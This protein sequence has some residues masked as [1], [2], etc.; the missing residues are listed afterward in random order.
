MS[1]RFHARVCHRSR[2]A[3]W[4][5]KPL[6]QAVALL[7]VAGSWSSTTQA[8][9]RAFSS[10]WF[11]DKNAVQSTAQRTGRMPD[12]SLAGI[13][14]SARQ[15]AESRLKLQRS[16]DNLNRTAAAV[17]AQQAAQAAAR[18]AAAA[19]GSSV[20]DGLT[21]GGLWV[22][23]GALAKWE[24]AKAPQPGTEGGRQLVTIEQTQS[25]AILNWD[26]FNVGRNTTV[27]FKQGA[28]D[29]VLNRVVGASAKP[30]QIQGAIKGDGT[31]L[32]V[33]QNG[34]IFTGTSQVN[35]RNLVVAAATMTDAQLRERGIYADAD[36]T[37]PTFKDALGTIEVQ[38][39]ARLSTAAPG[40]ATR[41]G[42][43]VLLAGKEVHNAGEIS[44]PQG[45]A[46]LAAGDSFIIRRGQGS[47]SNQASTTRGNEVQAAGQGLARNSG[48]I[49]SPQGDITLTGLRVEQAGVVLSTTSVDARGTIHLDA[50]GSGA[51][52]TL[53]E[54]AVSAILVDTSL[55]TALDGQRASLL[56]PAVASN[57]ALMPGDT[58]RR[59]LSL[60]QIG[61]Q[62][63]VDFQGGSLTLAT[64]GQVAVKA[65]GRALVQNG[66]RIDVGGA[67]GVIVSMESNN[68]KINLQGNEQRDAPVNRDSKLLN[69][70]DVWLDR[71]DLVRLAAGSGGNDADR[72]Y[73]AGGL[74]EVGGY[75]GTLGVPVSHWLAQGGVV[76]FDG[77]EVVTQAGS[78]I[79]LSGGTLDVQSGEI[80]QS[81]LR[82]E[83]GRLYLADRAPGDLLY[84]GLYRGY[85]AVS[86]R[87]GEN[88]TRRF[89]NPLIAPPTRYESGYTVGRDAG[90]LVVSTR[91]AVLDGDL[92]ND[93]YQGD[94]Q[95]RPPV[96]GMDGY[97]ASHRVAARAA[98]LVVGT[99]K[100]FYD[101]D[102][103]FLRYQLGAAGTAADVVVGKGLAGAAADIDLT[104]ALPAAL[105]GKLALDADRLNGFGLGAIRLAAS[106]RV[107][108]DA[109]L[110]SADGGEIT[111]YAPSVSVNADLVSRGGLI[112]AGNV[113][114]QPGA[115][116]LE[117]VALAP[118]AGK[119]AALRVASGVL[120]D[121]RGGWSNLKQDPTAQRGLPWL[122]G[123]RIALRAT[124]D[125]AVDAG[126]LLDVSSG[127]SLM[128]NGEVRGG[129]GGSVTLEANVLALSSPTAG[130]LAL[131]GQ[132]RGYGMAGAGKLAVASGGRIVLGG[133]ALDDGALRLDP[134]L[135]QSGFANYDV[136]GHGGLQ[137]A[138]AADIDVLVPVLRLQRAAGSLP[139]S[140][141]DPTD[142]LS[143][144]TPPRYA[145]NPVRG[146]LTQRAGAGLALRSDR[147][148]AGG[149]IE[150]G[151]GAR[152]AVD[153]GQTI[154]I[155]GADQIT[156]LGRLQAPGG[157]ISIMDARSGITPYAP[158]ASARSVWIGERAVLDV[159]G[160][161]RVAVAS[162]GR[163]YGVARAG[164]AIRIGGQLDWEADAY[165]TTRPMD[166]HLVLRPGSL[167]DA[168]GAQ[169]LV[170]MPGRGAT[171]L[172][173]NGGTLVLASASSLYL[174]GDLRAAAGGPGALGG[175]LALELMAGFYPKNTVQAPVLAE[176]LLTLTQT[177]GPS[178][179]P[180]DLRPGQTNSALQYGPGRLGVDQVQA[181]GFGSLAL[182]ATT[183]AQGDLTLAMAQSLRL[184]GSLSLADGA[185]VGSTLR[186]SAP[187][188][189]LNTAMHEAPA[190]GDSVVSPQATRQFWNKLGYRLQLQ[191]GMLDVRGIRDFLVFDD[192]DLDVAGDMRLLYPSAG[193]SSAWP[194]H[195][196]APNRLTITAAQIYPGIGGSGRISAGNYRGMYWDLGNPDAVLTIR[197]AAGEVPAVPY[198][199][200]GNL[201][202]SAPTVIQGGV[203][204]APFGAVQIEGREGDPAVVRFLPGS[205]T[206]VSGQGLVMPFGGTPD[207]LKYQ[208]GGKD[209]TPAGVS[210]MDSSGGYAQFLRINA[211]QIE[212]A[213]GSVL[214]LAGGGQLTGS[215]FV[216]G[217]GGSVDVLKYAMA[218]ANPGFGFSKPGN[219]VYAIVPG[220]AGAYAPNSRDAANPAYGQRVTIGAG[221]PGLP[222][223]AYTLL[224]ANFALLPGAF[225]VEVG[226]PGAVD[227]ASAAAT[228]GG[229]W[230]T[231][232]QLTL[233]GAD[234]N[235]APA[236]P[237]L[238]TSGD[239]VRRHA[240]YNET[241]YD[242]FLRA[243]AARTGNPLPML[244][245]DG[246]MLRLD[247]MSGAGRGATPALAF[248]GVAR[249]DAAPGSDGAKGTLSVDVRNGGLEIL[250]PGQSPAMQGPGA[251]VSAISLN[252][253]S[254]G[255]M[256]L[257][258]KL[259][260]TH[261]SGLL[262]LSGDATSVLVRSGAALHAPEISLA[263]VSGGSI[264]V[265]QGA[266]LSTVGQGP[267]LLDA[268]RGYYYSSGSGAALVVSNGLIN[269]RPPSSDA[270]VAIE[271][272]AC[273]TQCAGLA[274]LVS[275]GTIAAATNG[276]FKLGDN[277]EYGTRNLMLSVSAVNLGSAQAVA[278]AA[279]AGQLPPGL[280]LDQDLLAQ[281]LRG[282]TAL[283]APALESL[284]LNAAE[285]VNIY[286]AVTL[287]TRAAAGPSALRRL[288][289]GAPAL[290]GYGAA[291][292]VAR[293][294][295][296]EFVWAGTVA[297]VP[298]SGSVAP[299]SATPQQPGGA[300]LDRLGDGSLAISADTIRFDYSPYTLPANL[301]PVNRLAL[302]FASV[303]LDAAQMI[304][305]VSNGSLQVYHKQDGYVAGEGWRYRDG[306]LVL[307][308]PLLTGE[309]GSTLTLR[310]GGALTL[311]GTGADPA[312]REALGAT[313][314]LQ[315]RRIVLDSAVVLPSGRL[316]LKAD[317]DITLGAVSRI[318]LSGRD[319]RAFDV[320]RPSWGGDLDLHSTQGNIIQ[321]AGS[322][323]DL[324]AH[325]QRAGRMQAVALGAAAGHIALDG[326]ILGAAS[327][328]HDAGGTRVPYDA[329]ELTL[330]AQT[331]AD[332]AGL[333][334][335]LNQGGVFGARRFQL[336][337]GDVVVGDEVR[338]RQVEIVAD[339][340]SLTLNGR[341][342]A[343]GRQVGSI[344]LAAQGDLR[345]NGVLDAHGE[346]LRLDSYGKVIDAANRA[347]VELTSRQGTLTL[348]PGTLIDLRAG[349]ANP[350]PL[351]GRPLGT[352]D[353]N[354][355][356]LGG[357]AGQGAL[358]GS[359]D[360]AN[361]VALAVA[362]A[363]TILG[364]KTVAVNAFRRYDDAP[365]A[366]L[367]DVTGKRPQ[368]ITQGYLDGIDVQSQ[369]FVN[370]ALANDA[371][372]TRLAALG[373]YH[374]RPGVEIVSATPDGDLTVAGDLDLS[375][376]RY[377]PAANRSVAALR[378]YGEPGALLLRAGGNLNIHGSINDGFAPPPDTVDDAGWK[379]VEGRYAGK[380]GQTPFGED[381]VVPIDGVR[382]EAGTIFPAG[383]ALNYD[384]PANAAT[385]PAG[386]V[387]PMAATLNGPLALP[388]GLVL[389]GDLTLADGTLLKAGSVLRESLALGAGAQL[390]AGFTLRSDAALRAFTWPKGVALAAALTASA[391]IDLA[392]GA[393][394]P[395]QTYIELPGHQPINLRPAGSDGKQ[396][397]N[398]AL[399]PML[400]AGA[401]A[402]S[403][404][405]VAGADVASA[406]MRAR[407]ADGRGD[408][409]LADTHYGVLGKGT[410]T[411][412]AI[413]VADRVLTQAAIDAL[414]LDQ[415]LLG[416][417][418]K[419]IADAQQKSDDQFCAGT[420]YCEPAKRQVT[421]AGSVFWWGDE[422]YTGRDAADLAAE[423]GMTEAEICENAIYCAGGGR[424]ET[425]VVREYRYA[426]RAP[427]FSVLRTGTGDL[428][429]LA[430]RDVGMMSVFGV[431][432]AGTPTS[433]GAQDARFN[434]ARGAV[435]EYGALGMVQLDGKYDAA[436][437][438]YRAWYP[439]QGGNLTVA[440]GRDVIGD[441]WSHNSVNALPFDHQDADRTLYAS[442][443]TAN[444]LWRQGSTGTPG[445]DDIAASWW[446]NFGTYV[447]N[448]PAHQGQPRVVGFTGFGTLG[449]GNLS[450][451]AGRD[452]GV[453]EAR[454]DALV[455]NNGASGR[456]QG[457]VAA[458]GGTGR[459]VDGA[460]VLTGGGDLDLRVGSAVNPNLR[461]TQ[462]SDGTSGAGGLHNGS[463]DHLDLNGVL[464][465]LRGQLALSAGRVGGIALSYGD[466]GGLRATDPYGLAGGIAVGG[467]RIVLGDAVAW[468][469]TRGD[470]VLGGTADAGRLRQLNT[471]PYVQGGQA[472]SSGGESGFTLWTPAT[473]INLYS[474]G[475]NLTP[476]TANNSFMSSPDIVAEDPLAGGGGNTRPYYVYPSILRAVAAG[477]NVILSANALNVGSSHVLML[478]PSSSGALELLAGGSIL[479]SGAHAVSMSGADSAVPTPL[480]PL[481]A[482]G[483]GG[484]NGNSLVT[485]MSAEGTRISVD[486]AKPLFAFGPN[487]PLDAALRA[488]GDEPV[489]F[490]AVNGDIVGLRT[491]DVAAIQPSNLQGRPRM[492]LTWHE[493]AL[494]LA[495]R[496]GRDILGLNALA[497]HNGANEVSTVQAGRDMI[498]ADLKVAGPGTLLMQAG[499]QL[500]QDDQ[501]S[502]ISL[503][504][505]VRG[506]KRPGADIA[507]LA[508]VGQHGPDYAGFLARYLGAP[509]LAAGA[510]LGAYPDQVAQSYA[511]ELLLKDW[512]AAQ[513]GYSGTEQN[514]PTELARQQALRDADPERKRRD[515]AQ[516]FRQE[517][518]L[519][520][521]NWLRTHHGYDGGKDGARA[522]LDAL[523]SE[524][525]GIYARQL[526]FAELRKGGRE[527][528]EQDG[529]RSGSYL[530]GRRAIAA[531]F[532]Q[533]DAQGAQR[534]YQGDFTMYGGAG[535]RTLF[536]GNIQ[537]L[538]PGGQ[539]VLGIEGAPPPASAGVVTQGQGDIQLYALGNVLL[540]QSRIMTTFGG[541]IQAWSADGDINAGRGAKT[542]VI[543]TP[544]KRVYDAL[545]N[546]T[547]SPAAPST[548]AGI[549][550]LAPIPE[551]PAGDVDLI[552]PLGTIDAGEA[553]IRVS[554]NVNVAALHVVNAANIQVQGDSKGIPLAAVVNT[555]ALASAS[556]ASSAAS[557]AA[558]DAVQRA[559]N[560]ARQNQPSIISVQILGFGDEPA[561][562]APAPAQPRAAAPAYRPDG[563]VQVQGAD[564]G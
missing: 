360:G 157:I 201:F 132:V 559:Q 129:R 502:A 268:R 112:Q 474:A 541:H 304:T 54:S 93:T 549:A 516:D 228:R 190:A 92:I 471:S 339:G 26:T 374:L 12:G 286:G 370:A 21:P 36:A 151:E 387:L 35:V 311:T 441:G 143:V 114:W 239:V 407:S 482:A 72:W 307:R 69:N 426:D 189:F 152:V 392:R 298:A 15:Q 216:R 540:G 30:S 264:T 284:I 85:E 234:P 450:I 395:S 408:I 446:I 289:L 294:S 285:S 17:A 18:A 51:A 9:T 523:A 308:T 377:G 544:P 490:Y 302:G 380:T 110:R 178:L 430:G 136:N 466:G 345:I 375:N 314:N 162:D 539:Q 280:R 315:A 297:A 384:L 338:A 227:V 13:G 468:V 382:L 6:S 167:L 144:W 14:N 161:S 134:A 503:G 219:A 344:R 81:W 290:Y 531:L 420:S 439:D 305:G 252:A 325:N 332:F 485:N 555:G 347:M 126:S 401:T 95:T 454:G 396:G 356:R 433:L 366:A 68:L 57:M 271:V 5:L 546:I 192:V 118:E 520:L 164:G 459:V 362:G 39:G 156:V 237:L 373:P 235:A 413:F 276:A 536:G 163:R 350:A 460:L 524:Q 105:A 334:T 59:D 425:T 22:A 116:R 103:A 501:A 462:Q 434:L 266:T 443:S 279:A 405:A 470:I 476:L 225:R 49:Q 534:L 34:V 46:L 139:D 406:D 398:W 25:R 404:T 497:L 141:A 551:V 65:D 511:G 363:P 82:G 529:P 100:P 96:A 445:V 123:G 115:D 61:S 83:D 32:V 527:Y 452:A 329:A 437:A 435:N 222:A 519:H 10:S 554:G 4:R 209:I 277:V 447:N 500:R 361:D 491:G 80:R 173:S 231:S 238:L 133:P 87:W 182:F 487:T 543:Y 255:R 89:Y 165:S 505:I 223:G 514:A 45:Q 90:A 104:Q 379:L 138:A 117:E 155:T 99:Y 233:P 174:D 296:P 291:G 419:P 2:R 510:S 418:I 553:G 109:A 67:V 550:T 183:R 247:L 416:T 169:A 283:G 185:P 74:L 369:A 145:E 517:S 278:Q 317:G 349:V 431:Y 508:G 226:A 249:F 506:D 342:D 478:A 432:T 438:A 282:N 323:I 388:A 60:V 391:G 50:R 48:L 84:S 53:R 147:N 469:D 191:A 477:G 224:P 343:S 180:D 489:R 78:A 137:V 389:T 186:L 417:S 113:L 248:N 128:P 561:A 442:M 28:D 309:A 547:L 333:N 463:R 135:F 288:V 335:R 40:T 120:L 415:S 272:G 281:L 365:L 198:S 403:L 522:A 318:D 355:R 212:A 467:P 353:L 556:A 44:T 552:A 94:R 563:V 303:N 3:V 130:K 316:T 299:G 265:E 170:D 240:Q 153:P 140:G 455:A 397:R 207:G 448:D 295:A 378:G 197:R 149:A 422:S 312:A 493:A 453:R 79:N 91:S 86:R 532:P 121:A 480:R 258:G 458:V 530:R 23:E 229:S 71:R 275:E 383:R 320:V 259:G 196:L 521:V 324:S 368:L 33:N 42:G 261:D 168:S 504:A 465:N 386:T 159:A 88:A 354:A 538:T 75:L 321:A 8:Q 1:S 402:W 146:R 184:S 496:A 545:G 427:L 492:L 472:R 293:I 558:Q 206:S 385:L 98:Q 394:I 108:V 101:R 475:G 208:Y 287:D 55:T 451:T 548:G 97:S 218:D 359:G 29:A 232:G 393:L 515:L 27:Q 424:T 337:Q 148:G 372:T 274:R 562:G 269:L 253:L 24:G 181:G 528:N 260:S 533:T 564:G 102:G 150:I 63:T 166:R 66:A 457:L 336:K 340:G 507:V 20:P 56:Q 351:D 250:A 52:V 38:A 331:L 131:S 58:F 364:A 107:T 211:T 244:L 357:G 106:G 76:R 179:L 214:D 7:L 456:S 256:V 122:D 499:R 124:G 535:L 537:L 449:G 410:Q 47:D 464:V 119:Q 484:P 327:G 328:E 436:L 509:V 381:L 213:P 41:G 429:L 486:S 177:R 195:L 423:Y 64:G 513:F 301:V 221:V 187:Y 125:V 202:L 16:L 230:V 19:N 188:V 428:S 376:Y 526:Y 542:T 210:G 251:A 352:L 176:R 11:A 444:W 194:T 495:V 215:A 175:T 203:V 263:A 43:Y 154:A 242:A 158:Q 313:L 348:G 367:P 319:F 246:R 171:L 300:V 498:H 241:S 199:A 243:Q 473:A 411:V 267:A 494:P 310:A 409:I 483:N 160:D 127:A 518:E 488:G 270:R 193:P 204:R 390:G 306:D 220:F 257:G 245:A 399:A 440:A 358:A 481:F 479:A 142:V 236:S 70:S 200:F 31:V 557:G 262:S 322:V 172:A 371:L 414:H 326:T 217:R 37:Q 73:T 330:R 512:L 421:S 111:L 341:I 292:D 77:A 62:G 346:T 400:G 273:L 560:Q 205:I 412:T 461:A 254:P 525:Q